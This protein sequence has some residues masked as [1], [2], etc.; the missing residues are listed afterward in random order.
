MSES[1][2]KIGTRGSD[3]ALWQARRVRHLLGEENI[4]LVIIKTQGDQRT[5]IRLDG[6]ETPGLFTRELERA[7]LDEQVDLAVHSLKDLPTTVPAGLALGPVPERSDVGDVL[8]VR[9]GHVDTERE[10]SLAEGSVVGTSSPRREALLTRLRPDCRV[11]ERFRGNVPTRLQK[12]IDGEVDAVL[13]ARAGLTRLGLDPSPLVAFDLAPAR[14]LPAPG[15]GALGLELREGDDATLARLAPLSDA[16]RTSTVALERQVLARLEAGCHAALGAW[17][18]A[19]GG[20]DGRLH[21]TAG[22]RTDD[23]CWHHFDG[24]GEADALL[25][26]AVTTLSSDSVERPS[27]SS[28]PVATPARPWWG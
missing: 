7:L 4:E 28:E 25:E 10:L 8:L 9:P 20:T 2:L 12:C 14:W 27:P 3:L 17:A 23:G 21:L 26:R 18:R 24:E 19:A 15:Q 6:A 5:D 11:P 22:Q 13:L 16:L 1:V